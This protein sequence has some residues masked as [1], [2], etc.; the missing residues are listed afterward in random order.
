MYIHTIGKMD[1]IIQWMKRNQ[2]CKVFNAQFEKAKFQFT[3]LPWFLKFILVRF[4]VDVWVYWRCQLL[5]QYNQPCLLRGVRSPIWMMLWW[6]VWRSCSYSLIWFLSSKACSCSL[7]SRFLRGFVQK[8]KR[9]PCFLRLISSLA[10][11]ERL[12]VGKSSCTSHSHE[13]CRISNLLR[14]LDDVRS[15]VKLA[16]W[17]DCDAGDRF[18]KDGFFTL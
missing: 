11:S 13:W 7:R 4:F 9:F 16:S 2:I 15:E 18:D 1:T 8:L 3:N 17:V 14:W 12:D 10:I 5:S 6:L